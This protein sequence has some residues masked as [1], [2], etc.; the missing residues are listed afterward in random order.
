M[1]QASPDTQAQ[2]PTVSVKESTE[3]LL[4][5][6]D[7]RTSPIAMVAHVSGVVVVGAEI[8]ESGVVT[9]V[10][11]LSGP[12]LL[13]ASALDAVRHYT[14]RSFVING[15]V[16]AVRTAVQVRFMPGAAKSS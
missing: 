1:Q 13:R 2:P 7:A 4:K 11:A 12:E 8:D 15:K 9:Q 3:H 5:K 14:Y 10:V 16:T 6:I